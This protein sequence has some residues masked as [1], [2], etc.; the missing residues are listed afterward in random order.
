M[1]FKSSNKGNAKELRGS[2]I[3][4]NSACPGWDRTPIRGLR[5]PVSPERAATGMAGHLAR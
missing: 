2:K 1:Y 4:V 5:A 3:L